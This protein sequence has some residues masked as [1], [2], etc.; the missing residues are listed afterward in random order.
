MSDLH[1]ALAGVALPYAALVLVGCIVRA[2]MGRGPGQV[3]G[4]A[5]GLLVA[6]LALAA[7]AGALAAATGDG[8][9]E[10]AL[11]WLYGF[12]ALAVLPVAVAYARPIGPRMRSATIAL[13]LAS[14]LVIIARQGATGG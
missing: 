3:V 12:A 5:I 10:P 7:G 13:A 11:H 1:A 2:A 9:A 4:A 6:V 8:P 14:L